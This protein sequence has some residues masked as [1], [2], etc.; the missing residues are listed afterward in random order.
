MTF[1]RFGSLIS[2]LAIQAVK[3]VCIVKPDGRKEPPPVDVA[4]V[5]VASVDRRSKPRRST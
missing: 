5:D 3:T 4:S 2:D 1:W